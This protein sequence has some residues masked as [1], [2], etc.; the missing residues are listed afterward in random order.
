MV[1]EVEVALREPPPLPNSLTTAM[2]VRSDGPLGPA[3][4][5]RHVLRPPAPST[6][7]RG[8]LYCSGYRLVSVILGS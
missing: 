7:P 5:C 6:H 8:F 4:L 1:E 2:Q 3:P